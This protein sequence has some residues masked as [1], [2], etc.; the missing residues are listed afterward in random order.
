M[1]KKNIKSDNKKKCVIPTGKF[2]SD[3]FKCSKCEYEERKL[4][5]SWQNTSTC[6]RCGGTAYR[7]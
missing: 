3:W 1:M 7:Q 2:A 6:S 4:I 5:P